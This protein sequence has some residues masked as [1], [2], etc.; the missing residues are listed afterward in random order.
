MHR[1][2]KLLSNY[3]YCSRRKAEELIKEG[4]V[5]VN[6]KIITIGDQA[7]ENDI[8]KVDGKKIDVEKKIYLLFHKPKGCV[9]AL[10]D[11]RYKT[12]M[13]YIS[14]SE[15]IFPVG[16]LDYDTSGLLIMTNDGDFANE[17]MHPSNEVKKTYVV[18]LDKPY[19]TETILKLKEGIMLRD[20]KTRPA[21]VKKISKKVIEVTIHE[22][23][24]RIVKRMFKKLG[25]HVISLKRTKV[26]KYFLGNLKPG[27]YKPFK[28]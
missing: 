23:K 21:H 10:R 9:T 11:Q 15:R 22:G 3:G 7:N 27:E 1:V 19:S 18:T 16:R 28:I 24:N 4:R 2:Q 5:S 8:I 13:D 14:V 17:I 12:V 6:G 26:G 25:Y 20:G